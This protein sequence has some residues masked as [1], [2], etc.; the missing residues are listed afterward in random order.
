MRVQGYLNRRKGKRK[1]EERRKIKR[2]GVYNGGSEAS[3]CNSKSYFPCICL[4][5][6]NTLYIKPV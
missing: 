3:T 4:Q 2:C 6:V 1:E 5:N